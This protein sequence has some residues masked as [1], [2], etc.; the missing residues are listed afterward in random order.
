MR[1]WRWK[2]KRVER[3]ASRDIRGVMTK[4]EFG[5]TTGAGLTSAWSTNGRERIAAANRL[6][7]ARRMMDSGIIAKRTREEM[8]I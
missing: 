7:V 8:W 3:L 4:A 2:S 1:V 5:W 6:C